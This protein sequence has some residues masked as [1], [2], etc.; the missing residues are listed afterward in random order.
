M[1]L[2]RIGQPGRERP[3][4]VADELAVDVSEATPDFDARFFETGSIEEVRAEA[5]AGLAAGRGFAWSG[6]RFGP[7]IA[8]PHQILCIGLNYRAHASETGQEVPAEPIVFTKAPNTLA[9]PDD[10]VPLPPGSTKTDW[11]IELGVVIRSRSLYLPDLAAARAAIAGYVLVNDVSEREHQLERGGQWVKGKSAPSFN[12]CGPFL[13]TPDEIEDPSRLTLSLSVNGERRQHGGTADMIFPPD[14]IVLYLSQ[15]MA[16]EP[17]DLINTGTPPGVGMGMDP[18]RYLRDG[19]VVELTATG[20][21]RQ[22][23]VFRAR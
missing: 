12:P 20:L 2:A 1:K 19:D 17:G 14:E 16:L 5:A 8:R 22:R 3:C 6:M 7:P 18:P 15:F 23:Q 11:E 10:D 9:G 4:V 21:G 13:V